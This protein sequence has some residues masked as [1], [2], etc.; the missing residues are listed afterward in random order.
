MILCLDV[1]NTSIHGGVF[2]EDNLILQFRK[3]ATFRGS[4]DET[5]IFLRSVLKENDID[6]TQITNIGICS[7]V[8]DTIHS[9]RNA[10]IKYFGMSPFELGPGVKTGLK[11]N[12]R[13]PAEVGADRIANAVAAV[14]QFPGKNLIIIDFG[15]ATTFDVITKDKVYQGGT[16]LPGLQISMEALEQKAAKLPPVEIVKRDK[17]VGRSTMG[18]I[19]SGLYFGQMG[20]VKELIKEITQE[21]FPEDEPVVVATGGFSNLYRNDN[22]FH[23]IVPELVLQGIHIAVNKNMGE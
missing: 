14:E 9:L 11:I 13:N 19:Q 20:M 16:I 22:L 5:G 8:P 12:Y 1:G 21:T 17:V 18:S 15:T 6:P 23:V 3:T 2:K 7:V 10:C 4:S